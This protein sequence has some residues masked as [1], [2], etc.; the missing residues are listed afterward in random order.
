MELISSKEKDGQATSQDSMDRQNSSLGTI[1]LGTTAL[2]MTVLGTNE[3]ELVRISIEEK[4][5]NQEKK[6]RNQIAG[7]KSMKAIQKGRIPF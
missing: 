3:Y 6:V 2:G 4:T 1:A 5:E 7:S